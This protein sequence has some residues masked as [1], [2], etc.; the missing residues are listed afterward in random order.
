MQL[1]SR[2]KDIL[3][4]G[5]PEELTGPRGVLIKVGRVV[6]LLVGEFRRD[7]CLERAASLTFYS[8]IS[9]IPMTVLF[10][11]FATKFMGER[12]RI[13]EWFILKIPKLL[14]PGQEEKVS[15][16]L[17]E[18]IG[19]DAFQLPEDASWLMDFTAVC[20]LVIISLGIFIATERVF[21]HIWQVDKRRNYLQR[22]LVFWVI[23]TTSPLLFGASLWA[24][25]MLP[26]GGLKSFFQDSPYFAA[27]LAFLAFTSLYIFMPATKVRFR[28]AVI[29]GIVAAI[30]WQLAKYG[31]LYYLDQ[32]NNVTRFYSKIA[33]L[34][35]FL[36]WLYVTWM[37][38]LC[39]AQLSYVHQNL[40]ALSRARR[41]RLASGKRSLAQLGLHL[42]YRVGVAFSAGGKT[43][44]LEAVA[45]DLGL[46]DSEGLAEAASVLLQKNVLLG[47]GSGEGNYALARDP[48]HI[49]LKEVMTGLRKAEFPGE[50][51]T[52]ES[53]AGSDRDEPG[54]DRLIA[55][56]NA[57]WEGS[58]E[59]FTLADML[60]LEA[61]KTGSQTLPA[62]QDRES[63]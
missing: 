53:S 2:I 49:R 13:K 8:I 63:D 28:S 50:K 4:S 62:E 16:W 5:P 19:S 36:I 44:S 47:E 61:K 48:A 12:E 14:A 41:T 58:F 11:S 20:G 22:L 52:V 35:L 56:A 15:A 7:F 18:D 10:F 55:S 42:L 37:V 54:I 59:S 26:T 60:P 9:L 57:S 29:G 32:I 21:N 34:P 3:F 33:A 39:G 46:E 23:L 31:F 6:Y 43:P 45:K 17:K 27:F 38:V 51:N 25:D 24:E 40:A 30:L 1:V